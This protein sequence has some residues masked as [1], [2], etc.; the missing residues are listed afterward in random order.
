MAWE[1]SVENVNI[2]Y[3][4]EA[5]PEFLLIYIK[6]DEKTGFFNFPKAVLTQH[7]ILA[8]PHQKGKMGFRVYPSWDTKLNNTAKQTQ[9]WQLPFFTLL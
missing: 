9:E 6:Q 8:T 7:K 2:A 3:T 4:E 5:S 1:K